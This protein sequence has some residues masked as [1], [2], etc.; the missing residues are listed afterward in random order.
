MEAVSSKDNCLE[1][2][3]SKDIGK[4]K[5]KDFIGTWKCFCCDLEEH[6]NY[7]GTKPPF[8]KHLTFS[9]DCYIMKDP[10]SP[11]SK[12]EILLLGADCSVCQKSVCMECSFYYTKR[13]CKNCALKNI[14]HFPPKF[15]NKIL[16]FKNNSNEEVQQ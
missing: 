9:E 16:Q 7:K 5:N 14:K 8:A 4:N 2:V 15:E 6:Y 12:G 1:P 3:D 11:P 13:F 10:F